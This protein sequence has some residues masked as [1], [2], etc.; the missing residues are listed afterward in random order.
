MTSTD[1]IPERLAALGVRDDIATLLDLDTGGPGAVADPGPFTGP[2]WQA[3]DIAHA[4]ELGVRV[5]YAPA[6]LLDPCPWERVAWE[7]GRWVGKGDWFDDEDVG[8]L[9]LVERGTPA[10]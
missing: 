8:R 1:A 3:G 5:R 7:D 6:C 4:T 10:P 2:S 9:T